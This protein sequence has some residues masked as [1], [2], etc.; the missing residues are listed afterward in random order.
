MNALEQR[1]TPYLAPVCDAHE[2]ALARTILS[3]FTTED[4]GNEYDIYE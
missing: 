4:L 3:G 2:I 1:R